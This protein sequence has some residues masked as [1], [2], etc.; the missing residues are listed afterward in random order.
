[1]N[2]QQVYTRL[3]SPVQSVAI[4]TGSMPVNGGFPGYFPQAANQFQKT[5]DICGLKPQKYAFKRLTGRWVSHINRV[6]EALTPFRGVCV[7]ALPDAIVEDCSCHSLRVGAA[8]LF[9]CSGSEASQGFPGFL[10]LLMKER[11]TQ[12]AV[13]LRSMIYRGH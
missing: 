4:S 9:G 10:T 2:V 13:F 8:N 1:M 11:E 5:L 6:T 3:I 12:A 7:F